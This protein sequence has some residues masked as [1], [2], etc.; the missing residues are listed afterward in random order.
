MFVLPPPLPDDVARTPVQAAA[1]QAVVEAFHE[2][3]ETGQLRLPYTRGRILS[4][5]EVPPIADVLPYFRSPKSRRVVQF[6]YPPKTWLVLAEFERVTWRSI[7][8]TCT[9]VSKAITTSDASRALTWNIEKG[10]PRSRW[11]PNMYFNEWTYDRPDLGYRKRMRIRDDKSVLIEVAM[12]A[13][14]RRR[15]KGLEDRQ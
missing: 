6:S 2:A 9:I 1:S 12:Y 15:K 13:G 11:I 10:E 7:V 14:S 3:C 8:R 4:E 5:S